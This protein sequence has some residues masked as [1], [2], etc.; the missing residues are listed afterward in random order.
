M[1][2]VVSSFAI[3]KLRQ[4]MI[5][6]GVF[7]ID[8]VLPCCANPTCPLT[9]TGPVGAARAS[10]VPS[11]AATASVMALHRRYF[12][13]SRRL[14]RMAFQSLPHDAVPAGGTLIIFFFK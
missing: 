11:A 2:L 1:N 7:V 12:F 14:N 10:C 5:A 13:R 9:T 6:P 4:L 3:E 8:S